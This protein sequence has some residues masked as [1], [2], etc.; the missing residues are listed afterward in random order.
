MT[1]RT[2]SI[3]ASALV[4][5]TFAALPVLAM[6][7]S[8]PSP[9]DNYKKAVKEIDAKNFEAA[10]KILVGYVAKEAKDPNGWNYLAFSQRNLGK[11]DDAMTNYNVA[12][13][14]DPN[15][16]G[17]LEY[18]GELF[19]KLGNIDGAKANLA[20]LE[21]VC[22]KKCEERDVLQA[23]IER[24]KDGQVSWISPERTRS[25]LN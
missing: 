10:E 16:K 9:K 1:S 17:A 25:E 23:A 24:A 18:Q 5:F 3:T 7:S 20:K 12:L 4:A 19:L 8:D 21:V 13:G 22:K 6:G 14:L 15:H 2:F 11:N